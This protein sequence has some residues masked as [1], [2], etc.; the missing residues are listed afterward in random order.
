MKQKLWLLM[1]ALLV[2]SLAASLALTGCAKPPKAEMDA[3]EAAVARAE[4]NPDVVAYA[5]DTLARAKN[6]LEQ[7]RAAA[8][9]KNYDKAKTLAAEATSSADASINDAATN[10]ERA[11]TKAGELIETVKL[12]L[13][14]TEK[15]IT[16]TAKVKKANIDLAQK[17][18]DLE[19]AKTSLAA[20]QAAY[21]QGN[22][23]EAIDKASAAQKLLADIESSIGAAVQSATRKK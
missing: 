16:A 13:P 9:S 12:A 5:P 21:D 10:K 22:Y 18:A 15:L 14:Q 3:A 2:L 23:L 11:K 19:S 1:S 17:K 4:K 7:M 20:A 8:S 6:A